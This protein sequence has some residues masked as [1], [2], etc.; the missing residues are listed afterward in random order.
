MFAAVELASETGERRSPRVSPSSTGAR[1]LRSALDGHCKPLGC[2]AAGVIVRW[3]TVCHWCW[4]V[5]TSSV[6][7]THPPHHLLGIWHDT[8]RQRDDEQPDPFVARVRSQLPLN[9]PT[10]K[11]KRKETGGVRAF[12]LPFRPNPPPPTPTTR[13]AL[14]H[15]IQKKTALRTTT[16]KNSRTARKHPPKQENAPKKTR[17][18]HPQNAKH[19]QPN[20]ENAPPTAK[21]TP[22]NKISRFFL[23]AK[24]NSSQKRR[25]R[26]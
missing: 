19:T 26:K 13:F 18:T 25:K 4:I 14:L 8:T 11:R 5:E 10:Q 2:R 17:N 12:A 24:I 3:C 22:D 15:Y 9:A 20:R 16:K 23:R 6:F 7:T 21:N 1:C